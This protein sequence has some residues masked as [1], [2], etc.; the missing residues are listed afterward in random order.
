MSTPSPS[1]HPLYLQIKQARASVLEPHA[2]ASRY[3][4]QGERVVVGQ[5]LMQ[6]ASDVFLGWT[7]G[8]RGRH[9]YVRQLRDWKVKPALEL[10]RPPNL[11]RYGEI[12]G[13]AL[14]RAHARTGDAALLSG[15]LGRNPSFDLAIG[16]FA[17]AY[18]QQNES[19]Y[20]AFKSAARSGRIRSR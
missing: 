5:R 16:R 19:D 1:F 9:F 17:V 10:M 4:N 8:D 11:V 7:R 18:A 20:Q 14:A 12:C 13:W 3:D 6:T 2:G 15:Y